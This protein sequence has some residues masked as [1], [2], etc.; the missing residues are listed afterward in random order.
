MKPILAI[1]FDN[2]IH[3]ISNISKGHKL[4]T[5]VHGAVEALQTLSQHYQIYIHTLRALEGE[6]PAY[7]VQWLTYFGI[8]FEKVTAIKPDAQYFIDDRGIHFSNWDETL[9]QLGLG[10]ADVPVSTVDAE[11]L[12]RARRL[13][14]RE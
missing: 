6:N 1:D 5:P 10:N 11:I 14:T 4:G 13:V 7:V 2:T 12:R 8:P 3:D 9:R